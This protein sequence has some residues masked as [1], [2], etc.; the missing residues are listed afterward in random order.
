M[1]QPMPWRYASNKGPSEIWL[2][3]QAPDQAG[4][5]L[6]VSGEAGDRRP[7]HGLGVQALYDQRM[8]G[9]LGQDNQERQLGAAVALAKGM[10]GVQLSEE[11]R[12]LLG[13]GRRIQAS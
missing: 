10:N 2:P 11:V 13:E 6:F 5:R 9:T 7:Q 8:T 12:G 3:D 1:F 4:E